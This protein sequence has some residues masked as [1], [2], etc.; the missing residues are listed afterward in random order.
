MALFQ[1][2]VKV[3][4]RKVN[5]TTYFRDN[6]SSSFTESINKAE[7]GLTLFDGE[8][9]EKISLTKRRETTFID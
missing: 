9:V 4:I 5:E 7:E 1:F 6:I 2:D 8:H 3:I